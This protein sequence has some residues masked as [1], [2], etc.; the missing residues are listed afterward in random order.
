VT[1]GRFRRPGGNQPRWRRDGHELF[2]VANDQTLMAVPVKIGVT[3]ETDAPR[4]L[5][6]IDPVNL[7]GFAY[8]PASDGERFLVTASVGGTAPAITVVLNFQAGLRK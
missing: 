6:Q 2:H 7:P 5:F 8:Q 4:P 1:N 3:F